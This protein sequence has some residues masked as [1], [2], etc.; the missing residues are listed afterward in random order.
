MGEYPE[1]R[2]PQARE[3]LDTHGYADTIDYLVHAAQAVIDDTGLLPHANAGA[4]SLEDLARLRTVS[5]SQGMMIESLNPDLAAHRGAPDKDPER[6][7]ATLEYAGQLQ[8]PFTTGILIGIGESQQDRIR[9]LEAIAESHLRH[10]HIQEVIIQNFVPKPDTEMRHWPACSPEELITNLH[11][12]RE[13]LP[14]DVHL[15]APPNLTD[16]FASLLAAGIDDFGGISPVTADHVNP[17]RPWPSIESL[18]IATESAGGA[19]VP[20]LT[21]Y[22][23]YVRDAAKWIDPALHF[24]VLDRSDA[25]GFARDDPGATFPEKYE[26]AVNVGTGAEVIQVG[27]RST[28]WYSGADTQPPILISGNQPAVASPEIAEILAGVQAGSTVGSEQIVSLFKARGRDVNAIA[29]M[30]DK[31]RMAAV[32]DQVTFVRNRNI[33]YTN[34]CTFKC[35]FCGFSKGPLSLNLR[36][37]PYLLSDSEIVDRVL[38]AQELGATE[39]CLQ[40]G[41]HPSFDGEYYVGVAQVISDAAPNMHIHGFTALEVLE[42]SR[43][44]GEPLSTY[45]QRLKDAGL[46]SLPGTA[47]EI[48]SDDIRAEICPDKINTEEWL[49]VH[50]TAHSLGLRSNVTI[51]F[52]SVERPEHWAK[53]LIATRDLQART[54]GFTEFVPLPFVHMASPIY[55]KRRSRRGPT[56]RETILMHS[57]GRI[58]YHGFIENIQASWVKLGPSGAQQLLRAGVNDLGGTLM[59]ENIS[60]AAGASHGQGITDVDFAGVVEPLG[61]TLV[62][63]GTLYQEIPLVT[64]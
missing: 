43:R 23:E 38:E 24:A 9:A 22:P 56:W 6:R 32:G 49:M 12:A 8:I 63:R 61:R 33:N 19:L 18:R 30:A 17:E 53:H 28:A 3:W 42:G 40:G 54:G 20:R 29:E 64:T 59:D 62:Q 37:K 27:R 41:I 58:A 57:V 7:L 45:L 11:L 4:L 1:A 10:G 15:Q 52:G 14:A 16:D 48:L 36:G 35:T 26:D 46:K 2:Y 5:P 51:M 60:R 31:L 39:V 13:I 44:L 50:E 21:V 34:V 47:A 55:L 25:D